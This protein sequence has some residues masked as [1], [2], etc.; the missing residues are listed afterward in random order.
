MQQVPD[1][2]RVLER[3]LHEL[4]GLCAVQALPA[5]ATKCVQLLLHRQHRIR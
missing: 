1:A 5:A 4:A 2:H 3:P